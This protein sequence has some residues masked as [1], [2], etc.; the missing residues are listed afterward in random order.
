M[1]SPSRSE[2]SLVPTLGY[3]ALAVVAGVFVVDG[4]LGALTGRLTAPRG[5]LTSPLGAIAGGAAE[6]GAMAAAAG[7]GEQGAVPGSDGSATLKVTNWRIDKVKN[8]LH[9]L[10]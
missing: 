4:S 7:E 5:E 3:L 10:D 6:Q 1:W 2:L 8:W 9:N